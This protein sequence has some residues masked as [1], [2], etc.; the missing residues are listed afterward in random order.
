MSDIRSTNST[1]ATPQGRRH[2]PTSRSKIVYRSQIRVDPATSLSEREAGVY[3]VATFFQTAASAKLALGS[4]PGRPRYRLAD[5]DAWLA[6]QVIVKRP[7]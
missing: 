3:L 7:S 1:A 5:L 2:R 4:R 6:Q